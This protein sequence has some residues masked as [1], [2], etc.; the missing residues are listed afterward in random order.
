M[1]KSDEISIILPL[2]ILIAVGAVTHRMFNYDMHTLSKLTMNIFIPSVIFIRLYETPTL[3]L[4]TFLNLISFIVLFILSLHI[5]GLIIIKLFRIPPAKI[6]VFQNSIMLQNSGNFGIPVTE[7]TFRHDPFA[8]TIQVIVMITQNLLAFTYGIYNLTK[9]K[10]DLKNSFK[11]LINYFKTPIFFALFFAV[12][13]NVTNIKLPAFVLTV[14]D[15]TSSALIGIALITLGAQIA[16]ITFSKA[17]GHV[18]LAAFTRLI[19]SP[20]IALLII[21]LLDLEGVVAQVLLI[22]SAYPSSRNSAMIA[23]EYHKEP[24]FAAQAVIVSTLVSSVSV[25]CIILLALTL[26]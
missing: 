24:E 3:Q 19:I 2:F 22:S 18:I 16:Y 1:K 6:G 5:L 15:N 7:L 10:G 9:T 8:M 17:I 20:V 12:F 11:N 25:S 4:Q 26:F 23:L 14:F 13:F 21:F